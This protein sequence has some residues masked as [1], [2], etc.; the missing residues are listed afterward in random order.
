MAI[1]SSGG[2]AFIGTSTASDIRLRTNNTNR[3]ILT[4]TGNFFIGS[5][6]PASYNP[7][8]SVLGLTGFPSAAIAIAG[9][10]S[11]GTSSIGQIAWYN[12]AAG[13]GT[14]VASIQVSRASANNSSSLSLSTMKSG[15]LTPSVYIG[16]TQWVGVLNQNPQASLD[17]TGSIRF[18]GPIYPAGNSG[19][20]GQ[21]LQSTG[22]GSSPIWVSSVNVGSTNTFTAANVTMTQT[23][24]ASSYTI[25]QLAN[26][27]GSLII[28]LKGACI[29]I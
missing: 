25:D 6:S 15:V 11:T 8:V 24:D 3:G 9:N 27:L 23:L 18:S 1:G 19:I 20:T 21:Y 14:R 16:A 5:T 22:S 12:D 4:Q 10:Q 26:V 29:V 2:N 7:E 13:V 28:S 17:V